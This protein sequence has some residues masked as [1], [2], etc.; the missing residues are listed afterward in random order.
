ML[1]LQASYWRPAAAAKTEANR[2]SVWLAYMCCLVPGIHYLWLLNVERDGR[3]RSAGNLFK[4]QIRIKQS[5][6]R[7]QCIQPEKTGHTHLIRKVFGGVLNSWRDSIGRRG[8]Y[9]RILIRGRRNF[10]LKDGLHDGRL[11]GGLLRGTVYGDRLQ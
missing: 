4:P 3:R 6:A 1:D 5:F 11:G 8:R 9:L 2:D 7:N 10:A